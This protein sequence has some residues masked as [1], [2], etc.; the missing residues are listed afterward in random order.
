MSLADRGE[1]LA[2]VSAPDFDPELFTGLILESTWNEIRDHPEKPLLNRFIQG[3]YPPGSIVKMITQAALIEKVDFDPNI[4]IECNGSYQFGDR[5]FGC[6]W[7]EGHGSLDLT[8][9]MVNSCDIYFY[10]SI[11]TMEL[12]QLAEMFSEF[13]F[14][15]KT[16]IDIPGEV[17]G[18]VPYKE[19][20]NKR[21]GRYNWSKGALLNIGI[22]QGEILVTPIQVLNYLNLIATKGLAYRPHIVMVDEPPTNKIPELSD[23][24]WDRIISDM[25]LVIV[26]ENG[27]G[28][29]AEPNIPDMTVYGKTGTAENA[30][31]ESHA[32]FVGWAEYLNEKYS[33]VILLENAGSG[34]KVAA[35][36]FKEILIE[37]E[38]SDNLVYN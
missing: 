9:A 36:I 20:M 34:G 38:K 12:D 10:Q 26:D 35:P 21:H 11:Q 4:N 6:W 28:K 1:I 25:R 29:N 16:Q 33:I 15:E 19:Y 5:L 13:G 27:T 30:H 7:D 24:T 14:G 2:A 22:G 32:W 31:G 17:H 3:V 18:L 37:I 23:E 8:G